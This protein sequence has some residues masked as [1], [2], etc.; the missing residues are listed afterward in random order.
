MK[1]FMA[2]ALALVAMAAVGCSKMQSQTAAKVTPA[3]EVQATDDNDSTL[4][5]EVVTFDRG[6]ADLSADAKDRLSAMINRIHPDGD[7]DEAKLAVWS[8]K[9]FVAGMDLP[10]ADRDL[11][12]RRIDNIS[13]YLK[14]DLKVNDVDDFNMAER[15]NWL[16]RIFNTDD[17]ELK[18][19]YARGDQPL[20]EEEL[21]MIK[22]HGSP[23]S[24]VIIF[25]EKR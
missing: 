2:M 19:S 4:Y 14:K 18:S 17:A 21:R 24:A 6:S 3:H 9:A 16:A 1:K 20:S 22:R 25:R 23:S 12:D 13:S 5:S 15:S 11:A 7:V 8:D 10:K